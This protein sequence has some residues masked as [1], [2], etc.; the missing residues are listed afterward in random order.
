MNEN[1]MAVACFALGRFVQYRLDEGFPPAD[2]ADF[3]QTY[4]NL[5][6]ALDGRPPFQ[7]SEI[8]ERLTAAGI[9]GDV[10][11]NGW[12]S[13]LHGHERLRRHVLGG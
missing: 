2:L 1:D 9:A 5:S 6:A 7:V 13:W 3:M 12:P 11:D 8:P 4:E 10:V